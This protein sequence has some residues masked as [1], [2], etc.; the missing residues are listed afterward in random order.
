[1]SAGLA[2][3][4]FS[5]GMKLFGAGEQSKADKARI[6]LEYKSDLEDI[7]RRQFEQQQIRGTGKAYTEAAGVLHSGGSSAQG[8]L[9]TMDYQ[10]KKELDFMKSYAEEARRLGRKQ[11]SIDK[12]SN[13]L[14]AFSSGLSIWDSYG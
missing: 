7:R 8:Y 12:T 4:L 11:S 1:M 9:D 6:E 2:L 3:G 5:T 14:S 10:F 13:I